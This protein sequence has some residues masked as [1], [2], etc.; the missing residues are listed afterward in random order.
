MEVIVIIIFIM[1]HG[2]TVGKSEGAR[3]SEAGKEDW[4]HKHV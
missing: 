2:F 1:I 4:F 3:K